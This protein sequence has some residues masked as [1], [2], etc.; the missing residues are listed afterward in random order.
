MSEIERYLTASAIR[1]LD[2][3]KKIIADQSAQITRLKGQ[4]DRSVELLKLS[5][6][7]MAESLDNVVDDAR[8][9]Y[10]R[11]RNL[12]RGDMEAVLSFLAEIE[13]EGES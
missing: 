6:D 1:Q 5:H 11:Q 3:S 12:I 2:E 8:P 4:R 13:K 7:Y 10:E 9:R